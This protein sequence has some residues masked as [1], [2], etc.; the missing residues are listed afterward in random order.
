M[1]TNSLLFSVFLFTVSL[2]CFG[3]NLAGKKIISGSM[4][5]SFIGTSDLNVLSF[6]GSFLYGKVK[7]SS[8]YWAFG[9]SA[10]VVLNSQEGQNIY[11]F[12]PAIERGKFVQ[13]VDKLYLSPHVGGSVQ[14]MV[15]DIRGVSVGMYASPLRLMYQV[16][17]TFLLSAT[18]GSANVQFRRVG[19][20]TIFTVNGSLTNGSGIGAFYT[21]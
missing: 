1:K 15:G 5:A 13:L 19:S 11:S 4:S 3:Q 17:D 12:G 2:S 10:G 21:F 9:G 6:G 16:S 20:A 18:F 14:A 7:E 8:A